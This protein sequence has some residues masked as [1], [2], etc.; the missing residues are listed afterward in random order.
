MT[1]GKDV[2]WIRKDRLGG[3]K[4]LALCPSTSS[5]KLGTKHRKLQAG[6]GRYGER[7]MLVGKIPQIN[8]A[9]VAGFLDTQVDAILS[10]SS[11]GTKEQH[12]CFC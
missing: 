5:S 2:P 4:S 7:W 8:E 11:E 6:N 10:I 1:S 12:G 9:S 3:H